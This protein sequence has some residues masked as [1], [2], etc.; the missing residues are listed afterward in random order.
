MDSVGQTL[1]QKRLQLGR[2]FEEIS[3]K[4]RISVDILLAIESDDP[5]R[6]GSAF[7][8]R[9]FV[10][11]FAEQVGLEYDS[12]A[13]AVQG[14]AN[15][16]PAPLIPGQS[17]IAVPKVPPLR[18]RRGGKLKWLNSVASLVFMLIAC[19]ALYGTW[20]SSRSNMQA[21]ITSFLKSLKQ[22]PHIAQSTNHAN[23][24]AATR[25]AMAANL[26]NAAAPV[27]N[28]P[29]SPEVE[30]KATQSDPAFRIELSAV[31]RT[32]LSIVADGQET[33]RGILKAAETKV[34][35]GHFSARVRTGN[36]GGV[37]IVFNGKPL[38]MIGERGQVRT[39]LFTKE[40]YEVIEPPAHLALIEFSQSGE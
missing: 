24:V 11:Q 30:N 37:N 5:F 7:L 13:L 9:S 39:V 40:G 19:S 10:R 2:T 6:V 17:Q 21:S 4:T 28:G 36:A 8:Y 22:P 38:G 14:T 1:R 33:F 26:P 35:E 12:L 23:S 27:L 3:K 18:V 31:E 15:A 32:W 16:L 29:I 20:Q 25:S 34:L